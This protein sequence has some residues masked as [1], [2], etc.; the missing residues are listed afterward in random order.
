MLINYDGHEYSFELDDISVSEATVIKR[1]TGLSLLGIEKGLREAD[2]DALRAIYWLMLK[3]NGQ[4][5][6]IDNVDFKVIKFSMALSAANEESAENGE[7]PKAEA[8]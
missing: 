6:N 7:D 3:Q 2:V 1:K 4:N 8:A 5:V